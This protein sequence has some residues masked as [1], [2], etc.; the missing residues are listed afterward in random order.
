MAK[1]NGQ[2]NGSPTSISPAESGGGVGIPGPPGPQGDPGVSPIIQVE[3]IIGGHRVEISDVLGKKV[4]DVMDGK[5]GERGPQGEPGIRGFSP[6]ISVENIDGGHRVTIT[7]EN[8]PQ[9]FDV[10]NGVGGEDTAGVTSFNGRDGEVTPTL[11]DYTAEQISFSSDNMDEDTVH[12]AIEKLFTSVSDGKE[13]LASA[14]TD[15]GIST[16]KD[17]SFRQMAENVRA[18]QTGGSNSDLIYIND[19]DFSEYEFIGVLK[20]DGWG[21][22]N[23][24]TDTKIEFLEDIYAE[25][26]SL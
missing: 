7:D 9:S 16:T 2:F 12:A 6:T 19:N 14:I 1:F 26:S 17:V 10:L 15:K 13:L 18:I 11:G 25:D 4:F 20:F 24:P 5:D 22:V 23:V 3:D 21:F 8:G